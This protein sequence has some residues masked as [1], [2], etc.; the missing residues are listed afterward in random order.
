MILDLL[1]WGVPTQHILDC[2]VSALALAVCLTELKLRIPS[3][4]SELLENA[5]R[6]VQMEAMEEIPPS[7]PIAKLTIQTT[8]PP[9]AEDTIMSG[10]PLTESPVEATT[11][12][13]SRPSF[14]PPKP[15]ALIAS[16]PSPPNVPTPTALIS[17]PTAKPPAPPPLDLDD[18]EQ[19]RKQE[20]LARRAVVQSLK[21]KLAMPSPTVAPSSATTP[22]LVS[23]PSI[24]PPISRGIPQPPSNDLQIDMFIADAIKRGEAG[25]QNSLSSPNAEKGLDDVGELEQMLDGQIFSPNIMG[26]GF[27]G[28]D[29]AMMAYM[30]SNDFGVHN[31]MMD[32]HQSGM[33]YSYNPAFQT[34][35]YP[36]NGNGNGLGR[37]T[38]GF[39][40]FMLQRSN[41]D[42]AFPPPTPSFPLTPN[43]SF[44]SVSP[45]PSGQPRSNTINNA[46]TKRVAKRPVAA[47]FV[48]YNG[49]PTDASP[50]PMAAQ[51]I[52]RPP[53][54]S[55]A[56][57][58]PGSFHTPPVDGTLA[59]L[60]KRRKTFGPFVSTR[61]VIDVS[62]AESSDGSDAEGD[63]VDTK[64]VSQVS[65]APSLGSNAADESDRERERARQEKQA[66][67]ERK[68]Q[69]ILQIKEQIRIKEEERRLRMMAGMKATPPP[70]D[71][72]AQA[73]STPAPV[74][75]VDTPPLPP[76]Q[77]EPSPAPSTT[78]T[79]TSGED[80]T[81]SI[82]QEPSEVETTHLTTEAPFLGSTPG[83]SDV[84]NDQLATNPSPPSTTT[85]NCMTPI[86][87]S[88]RGFEPLNLLS[89]ILDAQFDTLPS[90]SLSKSATPLPITGHPVQS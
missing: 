13:P 4:L 82:K 87:R 34:G 18:I 17:T 35:F 66:E 14:L 75:P 5:E 37:M 42:F 21:G 41:S 15:P 49:T 70:I 11:A 74:A 40:S 63:V 90:D 81:I 84:P 19:Q 80:S 23:P 33:A 7:S 44:S 20:L 9:Q 31:P 54:A 77:P 89:L 78:V 12:L 71:G 55:F 16:K 52:T 46:L 43:G 51:S 36:H 58:G 69:Q 29:M 24:S 79:V 45:S 56:R 6:E 50:T 76:S 53:S 88:F 39:N 72:T 62:D 25:P 65:Q 67:W 86:Y 10:T 68:Q 61:L 1:G 22:A 8:P 73:V 38:P 83:S 85:P 28:G 64:R 57:A 30:A 59:P 32:L 26:N 48:E 60:H 2:G 3:N 27:G 47:D